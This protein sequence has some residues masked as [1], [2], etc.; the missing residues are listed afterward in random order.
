MLT[1]RAQM[2]CPLERACVDFCARSLV[3]ICFK[4][5]LCFVI[6]SHAMSV[7]SKYFI[8]LGL[9]KAGT[10]ILFEMYAGLT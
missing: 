9:L 5:L 8:S 1:R 4:V 3:T 2:H 7:G 10:E 6:V